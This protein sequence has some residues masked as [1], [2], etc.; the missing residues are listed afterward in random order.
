MLGSPN[1]F[2]HFYCTNCSSLRLQDVDIA[3]I[4]ATTS[5]FPVV[6]KEKHVR[7]APSSTLLP[8]VQEHACK[9]NRL[10]RLLPASHC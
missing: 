6:P 9:I 2:A 4:K 7:S 1:T 8:P 10:S 3:I 5:K